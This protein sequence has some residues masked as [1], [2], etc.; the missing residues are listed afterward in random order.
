TTAVVVYLDSALLPTNR[1]LSA[2][3]WAAIGIAALGTVLRLRLA[4][5]PRFVLTPLD[6]IVFF[7]ALVVPNL[8]GA[9]ALP[10]G[11]ARG[12]AK[13]VILFYAL[14]V[15]LSRVELGVVW[16][17]VGTASLLLALFL[18]PLMPIGQRRG[19]SACSDSSPDRHVDRIN[20]P[21]RHSPR[22]LAYVNA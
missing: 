10:D 12:I 5:D 16:L 7:V 15:L 21:A 9:F 13:L 11:G 4:T 18:R 14:E 22:N 17:R 8:P 6:L 3:S 20:S 19:R 1:L 2:L